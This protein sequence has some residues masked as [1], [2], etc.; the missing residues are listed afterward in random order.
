MLTVRVPLPGCG[1]RNKKAAPAEAGVAF[2]SVSIGTAL[3]PG[4]YRSCSATAATAGLSS[5]AGLAAGRRTAA[6]ELGAD[7]VQQPRTAA[8][9]TA[10]IAARG[11][12]GR[13]STAARLGTA[14]RLAAGRLAAAQLGANPVQ[15]P[16]TAAG[17]T[18]RIAAGVAAR[19][20]TAG[21]LATAVTAV[22]EAETRIGIGGSA[23]HHGDA[24][25]ERQHHKTSVHRETPE[26]TGRE[27]T[28]RVNRSAPA[29]GGRFPSLCQF[30]TN[31]RGVIW[32]VTRRILRHQ[33]LST[34]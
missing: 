24:Q 17:I 29:S 1:G 14:G 34:A 22:E 15:Q 28:L 18:T 5:T 19:R 2:G 12:T 25:D 16:R 31:G 4:R 8:G 10:R 3:S 33:R 23:K 27:H 11:L 6:A 9:I 32:Q 30:A 26:K 20:G 7:P 21:R 13:L